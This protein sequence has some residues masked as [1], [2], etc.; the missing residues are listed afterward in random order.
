M[1][2]RPHFQ[3]RVRRTA[4]LAKADAHAKTHRARDIVCVDLDG[5]LI[6]TDTLWESLLL[7]ARSRPW[8]L[9]WAVVWLVRGKAYFKDQLA[10]RVRPDAALLPYRAEVLESLRELK[11]TGVTLCLTTAADRRVATEVARHLGLFDEVVASDGSINCSG[12]NKLA[13]IRE[14]LGNARFAYWGDSRADLPL[15]EAAH[16]AGVVGPKTSLWRAVSRVS[17]RVR[18]IAP[19]VRLMRPLVAALRPHQWAKNLLVLLPVFLAHQWAEIGKLAL[20]L[21]GV[22]AFSAAASSVYIINDLFDIQS[23]RQHPTKRRRPF[24]AGDLPVPLGLGL[25]GLALAGASTL[26]VC[27]LTPDFTNWLA[28]YLVTTTTYSL[29]LKKQ[30]VIDVLVLAGLYT[31][32]IAAGA[33]A[34]NVPL[35]PWLLAFAMFFFLSLALGKRYIELR[36]WSG[37]TDDVLPGR[38]YQ[39]DDAALLEQIGPTSGYLAVLVLCLYID[40][41]AVG[42]LYRHPEFLWLACPLLLYWLTRFWLLARRRQIQYDPVA[43][44]LKDRTSLAVIAC[45]AATVFLA[46]N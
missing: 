27:C 38:G 29:W 18:M 32:R 34:V 6:R 39:S 41:S 10:A 44:A 13:A 14:R 8:Q 5:T 22:A 28:I 16:E 7:L 24:A 12:T 4:S 36:R 23:D 35:S 33:A 19:P 37:A 31:L 17:D 42:R 20:A 3:Q 26:S 15:W 21:L 1:L 11:A 40:S 25:A 46:A 2:H 43:F 30:I 45:T 9:L